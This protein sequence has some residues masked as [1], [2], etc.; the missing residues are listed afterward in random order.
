LHSEV[1]G[2]NSDYYPIRAFLNSV[3]FHLLGVELLATPLFTKCEVAPKT[4]AA[5]LCGKLFA[6]LRTSRARP[7]APGRVGGSGSSYLHVFLGLPK[8]FSKQNRAPYF[9]LA[10]ET[11]CKVYLIPVLDSMKPSYRQPR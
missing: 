6:V 7:Y 3:G 1:T 8:D 10:F 4:C 11:A 9:S 5:K 2:E